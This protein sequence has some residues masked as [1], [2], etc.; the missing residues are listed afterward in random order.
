MSYLLIVV[1]LGF[2]PGAEPQMRTFPVESLGKCNAQAKA[3]YGNV[4]AGQVRAFCFKR[5][6]VK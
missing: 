2:M 3:I 1:Y 5:K 4:R 6:D